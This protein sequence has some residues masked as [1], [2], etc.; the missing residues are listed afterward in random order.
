MDGF[1]YDVAFS[2]NAMD[3]GL[4]TQLNDLLSDRMKTFIYSER[5]R[6][7]AGRDGQEKFSEVYGKTARV[8]VVLFREQWGE[9]P[10]TRVEQDAIRNRAFNDGW[11]FTVF[12][13]TEPFPKMPPWLPKTRLYVGLERFGIES[14][15]G[16]VE[17]RV[18]ERGGQPHRETIEERAARFSRA[19]K[20]K[21]LRK[22]FQK[23]EQGVRSAIAAYEEFSKALDSSIQRISN[24]TLP[25]ILKRSQEFRI[26]S[27][28]S[29]INL[30]AEFR[31]VYANVLDEA[32]LKL[33]YYK[34]F[35]ALP[36]F[37]AS[38][39][40]ATKL[41]H[42]KL[43]YEMVGFDRYAYVDTGERHREFSPMELAEHAIKT[44]LE[45]A[46]KNPL[47]Y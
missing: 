15:A 4:A 27:G 33:D 14:A 13:P 8:V 47:P 40:E 12:I 20:L 16:V 32:Y 10:W 29:P 36:G 5:Q 26:V 46:E 22:N 6:E 43:R 41:R 38:Y 31:P 45:V 2:F 9:T 42:I 23:T 30:I 11:D 19:A 21:E 1:E 18:T 3:E 24:I 35:P 17:S 34:G 25:L 28:L 7:I 37:Y 44:Y 39:H